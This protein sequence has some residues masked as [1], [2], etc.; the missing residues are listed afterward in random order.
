MGPQGSTGHGRQRTPFLHDLYPG[1]TSFTSLLTA[2][3]AAQ[4]GKRWRP[5]VLAFNRRL[6]AE[7][8][9]LQSELRNFTY[10]PG[11]YR[12][13]VIR[14]PKPRIIAA[15]P[16]RERVVHHALCAAIAPPLERRLG[17]CVLEPYL[18]RPVLPPGAAQWH[19][20]LPAGIF[21][22][23]FLANFHSDCSPEM[24]GKRCEVIK[25]MRRRE[26]S[27]LRSPFLERKSGY[28]V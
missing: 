7:L 13:F 2:A 16:Y 20:G 26:M 18:E 19:D 9:K 4:R 11:P 14:D 23:Q 12:R 6:E 28:H 15:V 24:M 21:V 10:Q 3:Q 17:C 27:N 5:D 22:Q 1:L 25:Q 8:F